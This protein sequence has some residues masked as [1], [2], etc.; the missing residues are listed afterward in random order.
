MEKCISP[1]IVIH[2]HTNAEYFTRGSFSFFESDSSKSVP[3]STGV[4]VASSQ[5]SNDSFI[6]YLDQVFTSTTTP[7]SAF[8]KFSHTLTIGTSTTVASKTS[9][10]FNSS[11]LSIIAGLHY[12]QLTQITSIFGDPSSDSRLIRSNWISTNITTLASSISKIAHII[13]TKSLIDSPTSIQ[14][15]TV[16]VVFIRSS[17]VTP[18]NSNIISGPF[19]STYF[20]FSGYKILYIS[21]LCL[22]RLV[23]NSLGSMASSS[24]L[25]A[26]PAYTTLN[27]FTPANPPVQLSD[28]LILS[29]IF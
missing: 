14:T 9:D 11:S 5:C 6:T 10:I 20:L 26:Q 29:V 23:R 3:Q 12:N 27:D 8:S 2:I 28:S 16:I 13:A 7:A 18:I 24:Q 19:L 1:S 15:D 4:L 21:S 17:A 22:I 25:S